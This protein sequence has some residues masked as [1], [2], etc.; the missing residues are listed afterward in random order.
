MRLGER[1][2][3]KQ[4]KTLNRQTPR[5]FGNNK[6]QNDLNCT[7]HVPPTVTARLTGINNSIP[8]LH[9]LDH[10]IGRQR[11]TTQIRVSNQHRCT[12]G[13]YSKNR[14]IEKST[15]VTRANTQIRRF[16][17]F[18]LLTR[19]FIHKATDRARTNHTEYG[20]SN[21]YQ[22]RIHNNTPRQT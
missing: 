12:F 16:Q 13:L 10:A 18:T 9:Q 5:T 4:E 17:P 2:H 22:R 14:K 3:S 11:L 21:L 1:I 15:Q 6:R 20:S 8:A 7:T 19:H